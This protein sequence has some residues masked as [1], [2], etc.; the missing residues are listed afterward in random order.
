MQ[1]H[2][3][4]EA[5][6]YEVKVS[7]GFTELKGSA[8]T[9]GAGEPVLDF[10][11]APTDKQHIDRCLFGGFQRCLFHLVKFQSDSERMLS[12]IL[13]RDAQRW[14]R[15]ARGQF[16]I[17]YRWGAEHPEYQPDFVAE[18]VDAIY[19]LEA[20]AAGDM[21]DPEVI[22]KR[23]VAVRWCALASEYAGEHRGKPWRYLLIPHSESVPGTT[24]FRNDPSAA[25]R[26]YRCIAPKLH[27]VG[28]ERRRITCRRRGD[29]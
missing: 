18:V 27:R 13:D 25:S 2:Y 28:R 11:Q 24:L 7:R 6:D 4:E 22:E 17:F 10:R 26:R 1:N 9:A 19:M 29:A 3:R 8:F 15:P 20:K 12:V 5:S 23:N 16:Q 21:K 14:F